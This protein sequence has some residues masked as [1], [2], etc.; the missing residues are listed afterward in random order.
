[1]TPNEKTARTFAEQFDPPLTVCK[2]ERVNNLPVP[3]AWVMTCHDA[4]RGIGITAVA[5][6]GGL[7]AFI[8]AAGKGKIAADAGKV[9]ATALGL[10]AGPVSDV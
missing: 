7:H 1:M 6:G 5:Y 4:K 2:T 9:M 8:E 3:D 10:F